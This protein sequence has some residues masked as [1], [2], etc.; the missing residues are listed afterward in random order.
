MIT[1]QEI[2]NCIIAKGNQLANDAQK[3]IS[4]ITLNGKEISS[5]ESILGG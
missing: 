2:N 5:Y 1:L 3:A 4:D